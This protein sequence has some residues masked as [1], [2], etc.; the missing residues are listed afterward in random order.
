MQII[1]GKLSTMHTDNEFT[2]KRTNDG[3]VDKQVKVTS[4]S[5]WNLRV[6]VSPGSP[7]KINKIGALLR[8]ISPSLLLIGRRM[9]VLSS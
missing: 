1:E 7:L 3:P 8:T 2:L 9:D 4:P 5:S 6:R